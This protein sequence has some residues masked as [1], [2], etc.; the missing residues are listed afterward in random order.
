V[1][2]EIDGLL[3]ARAQIGRLQELEAMIDPIWLAAVAPSRE[4]DIAGHIRNT[5]EGE[6]V[7]AL[8]GLVSLPGA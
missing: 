7:G 5:E 2:I 4:F 8:T 1:A 3:E 6:L